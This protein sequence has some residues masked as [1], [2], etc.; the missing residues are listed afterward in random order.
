MSRLVFEKLD[1]T[2]YVEWSIQMEALLDEQDLWDVVNGT[3]TMP[4]LGPNSKAVKA[5]IRKQ[6]LARAKILL[7]LSN[8]QI[9]HARVED[10]DPKAIWDNLARIHQS[11]GF[12]RI[13]SL[14]RELSTMA[15]T[16]EQP[17]QAWVASVQD[18]AFRFKSARF[19]VHETSII[20]TLLGGLPPEYSPLVTTIGAIPPD[21]ISITSVVSQM[22]NEESC[23]QPSLLHDAAMYTRKL[24]S[25]TAD[26][27][28]SLTRSR[29]FNCCGYG[30]IAKQC[31][32]PPA[33]PE[34]D[35]DANEKG[36]SH[37]QSGNLAEHVCTAYS[38]SHIDNSTILI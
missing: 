22:L 23:Q 5:F 17:M 26:S 12:G 34:S 3:E 33:D 15:K 32:S 4:N 28:K 1:D 18:I 36:R 11:Q 7:Y 30:H 38:S 16:P 13:F 14:H 8:S 6:R 29:C 25:K 9:P 31:P 24:H 27:S 20:V 19:E 2:N 35:T 37:K 10:N 21:E